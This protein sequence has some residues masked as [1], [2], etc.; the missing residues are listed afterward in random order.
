MRIHTYVHILFVIINAA[1][2][3]KNGICAFGKQHLLGYLLG[4]IGIIATMKQNQG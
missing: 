3:K 4:I 2:V 1:N